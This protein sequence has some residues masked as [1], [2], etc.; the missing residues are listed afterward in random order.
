MLGRLLHSI[1]RVIVA[2][3]RM[4]VIVW[5]NAQLRL[6]NVY[7]QSL[8]VYLQQLT[9]LVSALHQSSDNRLCCL[10]IV[11]NNYTVFLS[12]D[13]SSP[14]PL[15]RAPFHKVESLLSKHRYPRSR[16][17]NAPCLVFSV[18]SHPNVSRPLTSLREA[19]L[20]ELEHL[21]S[22]IKI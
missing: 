1:S 2:V 20:N 19:R 22:E 17:K 18:H 12:F 21:T 5:K 8:V 16:A 15:P 6:I 3:L 11:D 14:L 9:K 4:I 10:P 7:L 13:R